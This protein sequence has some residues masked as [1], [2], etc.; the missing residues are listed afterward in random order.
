MK[1]RHASAA[2]NVDL[3][4]RPGLTRAVHRLAR[5]QQR[6]GRNTR[7][8]RA[9]A[10]DQLSLNDGDAQPTRSQRRSAV[11]AGRPAA[12]NDH[13]IVTARAHRYLPRLLVTSRPRSAHVPPP[14]TRPRPIPRS[15]RRTRRLAPLTPNARPRPLVNAE[16]LDQRLPNASP[17]SSDRSVPA[18]G[19]DH[20]PAR[21]RH[22]HQP[23]PPVSHGHSPPT[24][25]A[26]PSASRPSSAKHSAAGPSS[27]RQDHSRVVVSRS[28]CSSVVPIAPCN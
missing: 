22:V 17:S 24:P 25:V 18:A 10:A 14:G 20:D 19:A 5:A 3:G 2:C 23:G 8:V 11:L 26:A 15:G 21:W 7:P 13:V 12:E 9:L 4:A 6:L 27:S 1:S 28:L 16:S